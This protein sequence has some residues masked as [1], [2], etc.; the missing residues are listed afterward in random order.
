MFLYTMKRA[1]VET[2]APDYPLTHCAHYWKPSRLRLVDD[3]SSF[4]KGML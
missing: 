4:W 3:A 1:A 2:A